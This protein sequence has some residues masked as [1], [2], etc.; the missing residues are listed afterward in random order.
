MSTSKPNARAQNGKLVLRS[1]GPYLFMGRRGSAIQF[2]L[3][4][5]LKRRL[6]KSI[7][8]ELRGFHG[9]LLFDVW[10]LKFPTNEV[11]ISFR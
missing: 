6:K 1:K 10:R 4:P 8:V 5:S 2:L 11:S 3:Q 9:H 7:T